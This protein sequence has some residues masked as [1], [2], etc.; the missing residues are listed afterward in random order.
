MLFAL[1][2][3]NENVPYAVTDKISPVA[4]PEARTIDEPVVAVKSAFAKRTPFKNTSK[5]GGS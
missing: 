3:A 4:A 2:A 1:I 5:Y